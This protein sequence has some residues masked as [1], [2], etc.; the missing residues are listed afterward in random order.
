MLPDLATCATRLA[1]TLG[2]DPSGDTLN[3]IRT[4]E[5]PVSDVEPG[6]Q[7]GLPSCFGIDRSALA[8]GE[9]VEL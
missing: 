2:A 9:P 6:K 1:T 8:F 5:P 7:V 4:G 3:G